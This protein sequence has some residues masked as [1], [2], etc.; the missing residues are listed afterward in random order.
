MSNLDLAY[1]VISAIRIAAAMV[2][3]FMR[4]D[5][6]KGGELDQKLAQ[7]LERV[8]AA[9]NM[10]KNEQEGEEWRNMS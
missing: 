1:W 7:I 5:L 4:G 2:I 3:W 6:Q 9:K 10:E 8:D